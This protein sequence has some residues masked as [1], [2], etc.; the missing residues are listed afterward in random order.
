MRR[1]GIHW[2]AVALVEVTD[3]TK[4]CAYIFPVTG[5]IR[6]PNEGGMAAM[7]RQNDWE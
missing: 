4:N 6:R 5:L 1:N 2:F 7:V 3:A